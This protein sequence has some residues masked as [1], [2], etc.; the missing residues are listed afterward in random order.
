MSFLKSSKAGIPLGWIFPDTARFRR[1]RNFGVPSWILYAVFVA[2]G[3]L[4]RYLWT[5]WRPDLENDELRIHTG[6]YYNGG[7]NDTTKPG[8]P[9]AR[10]DNYLVLLGF[11]LFVD[12][13]E[14]LQR[15][16]QIPFFMYLGKRSFSK[17]SRSMSWPETF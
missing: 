9:L 4:M 2:A 10:D 16:F 17:F 14:W 1:Y 11:F 13:V 6:L 8:Q 15:V 12:S 7:L 3:L 5:A